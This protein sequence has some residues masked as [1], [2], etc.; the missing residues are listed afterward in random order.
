MQR[1]DGQH[2]IKKFFIFPYAD[3]ESGGL[4]AT[5]RLLEWGTRKLESAP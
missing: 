2:V 3:L 5:G 4:P 1:T